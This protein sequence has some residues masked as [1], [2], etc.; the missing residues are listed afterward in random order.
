MAQAD[1]GSRR[2]C[3][4]IIRQGRVRVNGKVIK[5][6]TQAD[7]SKDVIQVDG[8]R[9]GDSFEPLYIVVNKPKGVLSTNKAEKNDEPPNDSRIGGR[10]GILSPSAGWTPTAKA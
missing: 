4:E 2:K 3:E 8:E 9:I 7:P 5:L 1:I 6:G 10:P